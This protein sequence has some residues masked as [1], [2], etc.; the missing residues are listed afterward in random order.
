MDDGCDLVSLLHK[1]RRDQLPEILAG[2]EETTTGVIRLARDGRRRRATFPVVAVNEAETKHLFDNRYGTGQST[3]DGILRATNILIAG[4]NVV[5]AGYGWVGKGI[6][7]RMA[8]HGAHVAVI[9][10]NPVRAIEALMDGFQV[11]TAGEAAALGR[12]VRDRDRQRQRVPPR[13]LRRR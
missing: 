4:R 2:T 12:P 10:V 6:A 3:I 5:I 13:A 9:E 11:M 1:E 8:G 7:S